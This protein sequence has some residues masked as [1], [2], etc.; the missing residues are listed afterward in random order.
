MV[1]ESQQWHRHGSVSGAGRN[2]PV[3]DCWP[4]KSP[5][6]KYMESETEPD[7]EQIG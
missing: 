2:T 1:D 6:S 3:C 4:E 5:L 7:E